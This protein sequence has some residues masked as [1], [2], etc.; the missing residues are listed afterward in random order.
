LNPLTDM[1]HFKCQNTYDKYFG[2]KSAYLK[3]YWRRVK[4]FNR[5][6]D[7]HEQIG[8]AIDANQEYIIMIHLAK[9]HTRLSQKKSLF[10]FSQ[11][12]PTS[13]KGISSK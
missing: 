5:Q 8:S 3:P 11:R 7:G 9:L 13:F 12:I 10:R 6:T 2:K 4:H 1:A